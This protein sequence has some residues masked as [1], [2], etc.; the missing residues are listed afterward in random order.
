MKAGEQESH[1]TSGDTQFVQTRN[2]GVKQGASSQATGRAEGTHKG[3][4]TALQ[5]GLCHWAIACG[6]LKIK[7]QKSKRICTYLPRSHTALIQ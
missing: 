1:I 5:V 6:N 7:L 3:Q 4:E 2:H